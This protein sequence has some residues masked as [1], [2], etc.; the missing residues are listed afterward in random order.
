[1]KS[2]GF[3]VAALLFVTVTIGAAF[4]FHKNQDNAGSLAKAEGRLNEVKKAFEER[5]RLLDGLKKTS[6]INKD[7]SGKMAAELNNVKNNL[8]SYQAM[9]AKMDHLISEKKSLADRLVEAQSLLVANQKTAETNKGVEEGKLEEMR[10]KLAD[11]KLL[12]EQ[13][14]QANI[15]IEKLNKDYR[16]T[17][18]ELKSQKQLLKDRQAA[19]KGFEDLGLSPAQIRGLQAENNQLKTIVSVRPGHS[20]PDSTGKEVSSR[21]LKTLPL[22]LKLP[23]ADKRLTKPL[24]PSNIP[25]PTKP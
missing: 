17:E 3:I 2:I 23:S 14:K 18:A 9:G 20:V 24:R 1:M 25:D 6:D 5:G 13:L 15:N 21:T 22:G 8:E 11:A 4:F 12:E 19:I 16:V 10:Q 7:L